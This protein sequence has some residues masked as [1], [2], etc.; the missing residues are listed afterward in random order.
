MKKVS[1]VIAIVAVAVVVG[2]GSG[3]YFTHKNGA[4]AA[5]L[6]AEEAQTIAIEDAGFKADEVNVLKTTLDREDMDYEV[7]FVVSAN[8]ERYDYEI[9]A[10]SGAI[11]SVDREQGRSA[12][13]AQSSQPA[14]GNAQTNANG[15][16]AA[17][18]IT[19]DD[20]KNI[21]LQHAGVNAADV[22]YTDV[23][24]DYDDGRTEWSVDF[25]TSSHEYDYEIAA[26][27]GSILKSEK[28]AHH[29]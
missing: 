20:A 6:S 13:A 21:A 15:P 19:A 25:A 26:S 1:I 16:Q 28:E 9:D 7:E 4:T 8:N 18:E 24:Y 12:Q 29:R 27:D 23:S 2:I 17:G 22:I 14:A 11:L 5:T 3:Y 10:R